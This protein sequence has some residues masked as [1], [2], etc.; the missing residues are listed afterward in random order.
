M[1]MNIV[2]DEVQIAKAISLTGIK[3][4]STLLQVALQALIERESARRLSLLG[5]SE[6]ALTPMPRRCAL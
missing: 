4:I 2:L 5:R 1:Y 6:P 3:E